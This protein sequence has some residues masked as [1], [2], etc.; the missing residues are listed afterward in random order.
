MLPKIILYQNVH[1]LP[2]K[3]Q[4]QFFRHKE[5]KNSVYATSRLDVYVL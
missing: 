4:K 2:K 5:S 3:I 1:T